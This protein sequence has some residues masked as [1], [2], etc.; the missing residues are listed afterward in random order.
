MYNIVYIIISSSSSS[1]ST[2]T[3]GTATTNFF[4]KLSQK[5]TLSQ[6]FASII[7]IIKFY[8]ELYHKIIFFLEAQM[9]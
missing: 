8:D 4:S 3:I 5:S 6:R 2:I 9:A 7:L 1:S